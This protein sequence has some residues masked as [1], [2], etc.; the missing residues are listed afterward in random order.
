ML[1][2][3]YPPFRAA[4]DIE[5]LELSVTGIR[6]Y[7]EDLAGFP[8]D[9]LRRGWREVRRTHKPERWPTINAI[10]EAIGGTAQERRKPGGLHTASPEEQELQRLAYG[11]VLMLN[12][13]DLDVAHHRRQAQDRKDGVKGGPRY[14]NPYAGRAA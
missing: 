14:Y 11:S 8:A 7:A 9:D 12:V 3:F 4:D 10:L 2:L 5:M 13:T 6:A 1:T